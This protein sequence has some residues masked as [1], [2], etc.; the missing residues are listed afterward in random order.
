MISVRLYRLVTKRGVHLTVTLLD[1]VVPYFEY[2]NEGD[3]HNRRACIIT[4]KAAP[5]YGFPVFTV[6]F[7][8]GSVRTTLN[9]N[10]HP[11]YPLAD[12]NIG[13]LDF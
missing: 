5:M 4:G 1:E 6:R 13:H 9:V 7:I 10:L 8:D 2:R 11:A 12:Q 3:S